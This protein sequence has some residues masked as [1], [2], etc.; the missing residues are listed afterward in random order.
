MKIC[1]VIVTYSDRYNLLVQVLNEL[2]IQKCNKIIIV[3]NNSKPDSLKKIKAYIKSH[4]GKVDIILLPENTGSANGFAAGIR[5]AID[6]KA[7]DFIWLLDDDNKPQKDSLELLKQ[8]WIRN[9]LEKS[10]T[11]LL[12][13]RKRGGYSLYERAIDEGKPY[14]LP[15]PFNVFR[16]F[17]YRN[18]ILSFFRSDKKSVEHKVSGIINAA[19]YGGLFFHKDLIKKIGYPDKGMVLYFD[20]YEFTYRIHKNNGKIY[21]VTNSVINDVE[22]SW[23]ELKSGNALTKISLESNY[24]RLYYSIR[25]RVY[26]EMKDLVTCRFEYY[27]NMLIYTIILIILCAVRFKFKNIQIYV[28]AL[29][30]GLYKKMGINKKY[31][32]S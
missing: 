21:L 29:F 30:H 14:L 18:S 3:S 1:A 20:D 2:V 17:H 15:G 5:Y 27:L 28:T 23:H 19:P 31:K 7:Y 10:D 6:L 9:K 16:S 24:L 13:L 26:F 11:A 12:S 32:L 25:N 22:T 4:T 8:F